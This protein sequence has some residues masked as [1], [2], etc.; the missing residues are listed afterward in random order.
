MRS[1]Q[2]NFGSSQR[3]MQQARQHQPHS[4]VQQGTEQGLV[5]RTQ[6]GSNNQLRRGLWGKRGLMWH[7][8]YRMCMECSLIV[9]NV[10]APLR[11]SQQGSSQENSSLLHNTNQQGTSAVWLWLLRLCSST[12]AGIVQSVQ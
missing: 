11:K 12:L 8:D 10:A 2:D 7:N 3:D 4:S 9:R 1:D 6:R 5:W